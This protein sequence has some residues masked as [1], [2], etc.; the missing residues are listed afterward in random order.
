MTLAEEVYAL[1]G[2]MPKEELYGLVAQ[3]RRVPT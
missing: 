1:S 2:Q 3:L